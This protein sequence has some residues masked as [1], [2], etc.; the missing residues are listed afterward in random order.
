MNF[1]RPEK[2][3]IFRPLDEE[4][5]LI[6]KMGEVCEKNLDNGMPPEEAFFEAW[7]GTHPE[8]ALQ[9]S[10]YCL[11]YSERMRTPYEPTALTF[12]LMVRAQLD[13]V[14]IY[15]SMMVDKF[16]SHVKE[17]LDLHDHARDIIEPCEMLEV[18]CIPFD[19]VPE[20]NFVE[21]QRVWDARKI[22]GRALKYIA[23]EFAD[24]RDRIRRCLRDMDE[25]FREK[26]FD[27]NEAIKV[28][29][30]SVIDPEDENRVFGFREDKG[31]VYYCTSRQEATTLERKLKNQ[32]FTVRRELLPWK[33]RVVR[34]LEKV[35]IVFISS[36][37]K[38][39]FSI[40]RKLSSGGRYKDLRGLEMILCAV[41]E[42]GLVRVAHR[43]DVLQFVE[44]IREQVTDPRLVIQDDEGEDMDRSVDYWDQKVIWAFVAEGISA[45]VELLVKCAP[46]YLSNKYSQ[47]DDN[48]SIR[49]R[50]QLKRV[51][52]AENWPEFDWDNEKL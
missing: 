17:A 22:L 8:E 52:C 24:P 28:Y 40:D 38:N 20:E 6:L 14:V 43:V 15:H 11:E 42:D 1:I 44:V 12:Y 25:I 7:M 13:T 32:G 5:E 2:V 4:I 18:A 41:I 33:C 49:R 10:G 31:E 9:F 37:G 19:E 36:R 26:L 50:R 23:H 21:Q 39:A 48:H 16:F 45:T 34:F 30:V 46:D 35:F 27:S 51:I 3:L 47:G 29:F